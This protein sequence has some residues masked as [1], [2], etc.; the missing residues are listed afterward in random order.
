MGTIL[1]ITAVMTAN[2]IVAERMLMIMI[3][4]TTRMI[5]I[6]T[7]TMAILIIFNLIEILDF[8]SK[9]QDREDSRK[10]SGC[11]GSLCLYGLLAPSRAG[12]VRRC[13]LSGPLQG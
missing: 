13:Q 6:V 10:P 4:V 8:D 9:A 1:V 3:V 7:I 2:M 12:P 5:M 11:V